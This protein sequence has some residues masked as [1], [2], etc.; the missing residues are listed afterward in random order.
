[1]DSLP[2][3][4]E[5]IPFLLPSYVKEGMRV[6]WHIFGALHPGSSLPI[7]PRDP[8]VTFGILPENPEALARR[9]AV[10]A[11]A[12]EAFAW[13]ALLAGIGL[14]IFFIRLILNLL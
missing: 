7:Q 3:G 10:T 2:A 6:R 1:M 11:C 12:L 4:E 13:L 9:Y 5:N 8:F 14:N